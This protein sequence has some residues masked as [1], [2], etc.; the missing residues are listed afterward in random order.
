[1]KSIL[2]S[3]VAAVVLVG[4]GESQSPKPPTAKAPDISIHG[5]AGFGNIEAVKQ[6]LAAGTDVNAKTGGGGTPLHDAAAEGH[7]EIAELLIAKGADV[8]AKM[9]DGRTPLDWAVFFKKTETADLLRKHGGK[10][11]KELKEESGLSTY[12]IEQIAAEAHQSDWEI[13]EIASLAFKPGLWERTGTGGKQFKKIKHVRGRYV[14]IETSDSKGIKR[15]TEVHSYDPQANLMHSN[16]INHTTG[17]L[18]SMV[19]IPSP[20]TRSVS[21]KSERRGLE[22]TLIFDENGLGAKL[23][24]RVLHANRQELVINAE[25]KRVGDLP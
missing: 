5:A 9:L 1:M 16:Y 12:E 22:M 13:P 20:Q 21:W 14:V 23:N 8:N 17:S 25:L 19:G 7:K 15:A 10:T 2:V 6:H 18:I 11:A 4:C 24:G 3:I